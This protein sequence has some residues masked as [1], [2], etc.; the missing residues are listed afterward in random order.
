MC[1]KNKILKT[2]PALKDVEFEFFYDDI[3]INLDLPFFPEK[4][5]ELQTPIGEF[6]IYPS[7]TDSASISFINGAQCTGPHQRI[8]Q[9]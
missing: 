6:V 4:Y 7:F 8:I 1:Y 3:K 2:D 5:F 9:E